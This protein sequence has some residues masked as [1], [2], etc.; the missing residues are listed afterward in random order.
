MKLFL[1]TFSVISLSGIV[2]CANQPEP[3]KFP[4]YTSPQVSQRDVNNTLQKQQLFRRLESRIDKIRKGEIVVNKNDIELARSYTVKSVN[5][6]RP[7]NS[8]L[9]FDRTLGLVNTV[10]SS[11][12]WVRYEVAFD[13]PDPATAKVMWHAL[14][15]LNVINKVVDTENPSR[16]R[17]GTFT[18]G[19]E[20]AQRKA[21]LKRLLDLDL[22]NIRA[23]HVR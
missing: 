5:S 1:Y 21:Y 13:L 15:R 3:V 23:V 4:V 16:I 10:S 22:V 9:E 8:I 2:G 7:E 14:E 11:S 6:D 12:N 17:V 19:K 20:A 18:T